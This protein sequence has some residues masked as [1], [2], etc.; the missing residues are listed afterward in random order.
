VTGRTAVV[1]GANGYVGSN[2]VHHLLCGGR[3]VVALARTG[4][5]SVREAVAGAVAGVD[6]PGAPGA[7]HLEVV[8]Y[9]LDR[10]DL[11]LDAAAL[12]RTFSEPCD[13]W[14]FAA[15]LK[16]LPGSLRELLAVNVEGTRTTLECFRRHAAPGSRYFLVSTAYACGLAGR[17][18]VPERWHDEAPPSAFRNYYEYSK[19]QGELVLRR[20]VETGAVA[21][22]V[23]RLGLVVGDSRTLR[24]TSTYGLYDFVKRSAR[25]ARRWPG[26]RVR[27][28]GDPSATLS[29]LPVDVCAAWLD[30]A[31]GAGAELLRPPIVHVVDGCAIPVAQGFDIVG[32]HVPIRLE[33]VPPEAVEREPLTQLETLFEAGMAFAGRYMEQAA[34]FDTTNLRRLLRSEAVAMSPEL[35]DA[36]IGRFCAEGAAPVR[37]GMRP[38]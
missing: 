15:S 29:Y 6:R 12:G 27:I 37:T 17:G 22:A 10:P 16:F 7:A 13:Y 28:V 36:L 33:L 35:L 24:T 21:G 11:G 4:A 1:D 9:A 2:F 38:A 18:A 34:A 19:R 20:H 31:A 32:R 5:D 3:R 26:E 14:H 23:L 30:R 25:V 8:R